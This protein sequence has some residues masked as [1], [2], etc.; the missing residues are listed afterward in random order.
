MWF[1]W[2]LFMG[3]CHLDRSMQDV[4]ERTKTGGKWAATELVTVDAWSVLPYT[5]G[6]LMK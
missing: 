2:S 1:G 5:V 3:D 4:L 6:Y